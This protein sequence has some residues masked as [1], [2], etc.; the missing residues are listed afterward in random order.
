MGFQHEAIASDSVWTQLEVK[1]VMYE[2]FA[3]AIIGVYK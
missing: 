3:S 1:M 2:M